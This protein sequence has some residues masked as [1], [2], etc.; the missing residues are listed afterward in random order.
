MAHNPSLSPNQ[1]PLSACWDS[2]WAG[3]KLVCSHGTE[4]FMQQLA[5]ATCQLHP[6]RGADNLKCWGTHSLRGGA[7]VTIH[8]AGISAL[9]V[10]W[11]MYW[12]SMAFMVCLHNV[13]VVALR[14]A[15]ACDCAHNIPFV[16]VSVLKLA[17]DSCAHDI[18]FVQ[19]SL[20][21]LPGN[22][23]ATQGPWSPICCPSLEVADQMRPS[24]MTPLALPVAPLRPKFHIR[25]F[26][27]DV[28]FFFGM[29]LL[30]IFR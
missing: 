3:V 10:Q 4:K 13:V 24:E 29:R 26:D 6:V 17:G 22:S 7:C 21:K 28:L 18:P 23:Y 2:R 20:L 19:I 12:R 11:M 25:G 5:G 27:P 8:S 1:T 30:A 15:Q 14:H 16:H 9:D